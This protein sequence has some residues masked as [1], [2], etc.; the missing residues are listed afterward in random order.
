MPQQNKPTPKE[1]SYRRDRGS[2]SG[3]TGKSKSGSIVGKIT[4]KLWGKVTGWDGPGR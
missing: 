2:K 1:G 4:Q 3:T